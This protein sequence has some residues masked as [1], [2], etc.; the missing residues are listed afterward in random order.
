MQT[1]QIKLGDLRPA[2]YN[3]RIMT[4][5]EMA[6]LKKSIA[7]FGFVEPFVVNRHACEKCGDRN[8][9]LIGGH[10]RLAALLDSAHSTEETQPATFVD[11]H[12]SQEQ[13]LNIALN[14]I[15][16]HFDTPKLKQ[17]IRSVEESQPD[18]DLSVTGFSKSELANLLEPVELPEADAFAKVPDSDEPETQQ[19]SFVLSRNQKVRVLEAV[20]KARSKG[21][22]PASQDE[23]ENFGFALAEIARAYTHGTENNQPQS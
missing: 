16:G 22:L 4:E 2:D 11:L 9:V 5:E 1:E 18:M 10:Q 20:A 21:G 13:Q 3:P 7:T 23:E 17:L 15:T 19:M 12:I 6:A 14:K 8:N